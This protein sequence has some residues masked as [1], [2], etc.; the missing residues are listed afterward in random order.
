MPEDHT[1]RA[2]E[3]NKLS[4]ENSPASNRDQIKE[5]VN[6]LVSHYHE[7][8]QI[9]FGRR[10]KAVL[11]EHDLP[12]RDLGL[13]QSWL[14]E[15]HRFFIE[16]SNQKAPL[17]YAS[18]W[19]LDNYY[20]IRQA[21]HQIE[22]DL[23]PGFYRQLP[24]LAGGPLNGYPRIY[25]IARTLL[26]FQEL[27]LDP[28]GLQT[29]LI[30]FQER[31]PL[32]MGELWAL[33]IFLRYALIEALA[34]ALLWLIRPVNLPNLP[35]YVPHI[36]ETT[37]LIQTRET[38]AGDSTN[39]NSIANIILSLRT[40]S[41]QD[42]SDFFESISRVEQ[43][44]R[45]DPAGIYSQMDF[46]TRDI[47]RNKIEAISF[48]SS[49]SERELAEI[50]LDLARSTDSDNSV[51]SHSDGHIGEFLLGKSQAVLERKIGYRPGIKTALKRWVYRHATIF[52]FTSILLLAML[53]LVSIALAVYL[54]ETLT[55]VSYPLGSS[56]L[57]TAQFSLGVLAQWVA[58]FLLSVT[59]L[60]PVLSV[61]TSLVS[62]LITLLVKPRILPKLDF[63][64]AVPEQFQTLVVIPAMISSHAEID[65][66]VHQLELHYLRNPEPGLLFA[67]LTD[68]NDADSE[69]LPEDEGLVQYALAA[70]KALNAKY[71]NALP[72]KDA[73]SVTKAEQVER[74]QQE[75]MNLFYFLHR[76]R[77]WNPSEGKW[78]GWERKRGKLHELNRLLRGGTDLS[79]ITLNDDMDAKV[80]LLYTSD[81]ADE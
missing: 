9:K 29:I 69:S 36:L 58:V 19:V 49:R 63:K 37:G 15:A 1:D 66:L 39:N 79:F 30:Q 3:Q 32:T 6:T 14:D 24:K 76:R 61:S 16:E 42:W 33:P 67:L 2:E 72:G 4:S 55:V 52:Y 74:A 12:G 25:A 5:L 71:K 53:V 51:S 54:P 59:L 70:I 34:R 17:T 40:I 46:K 31:V 56:S 18:E 21:I 65:S 81:A 48:A 7:V 68:F 75:D 77:L 38:P 78:I 64:E 73:E 41:E 43:T 8:S 13:Y 57:N 60:I 20:L 50:T 45:E 28:I 35:A 10:A 27:L 22:E 23:P 80:C 62:W 47:Y 11:P 26:S 44:L